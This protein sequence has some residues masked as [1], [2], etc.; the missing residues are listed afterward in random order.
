MWVKILTTKFLSK[1]V[2][3]PRIPSLPRKA[4]KIVLVDAG[5][6]NH[7]RDVTSV[8]STPEFGYCA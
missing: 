7:H 1:A 8:I 6:K 4:L 3:G 5:D 2:G